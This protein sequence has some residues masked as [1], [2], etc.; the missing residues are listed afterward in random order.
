MA[1]VTSCPQC[2]RKL[3][4]PD[5][6]LGKKVKCPGCGLTFTAMAD[7]PGA[8]PPSPGTIGTEPSRRAMPSPPP[9]KI[10][11]DEEEDDEVDDDDRADEYD[12][13]RPKATGPR[14]AWMSVRLGIIL[15]LCAILGMV[16]CFGIQLIGQ[17]VLVNSMAGR[18]NPNNPVPDMSSLAIFGVCM[19][20]LYLICRA[21]WVA[22]YWFF[23]QVP[24]RSGA[25]PLAGIAFGTGV[26][27]IVLGVITSILMWVMLGS[28]ANMAVDPRNPLGMLNQSVTTTWVIGILMLISLILNLTEYFCCLFF[29]KNVADH[30]RSKGVATSLVYEV[31]FT[32]ITLVMTLMLLVVPF[33]MVGAMANGGGGMRSNGDMFVLL[34]GSCG[35]VTILL[36]LGLVVW[37]I[38]TQFLMLGVVNKPINRR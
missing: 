2:Q 29:Y 7:S 16:I 15:I 21:T 38:V 4:V 30:L 5:E 36:F 19:Q 3:R 14:K 35:C 23:L 6:L 24:E 26:G 33:L 18:F 22:G 12:E 25:K 8:P 27:S 13:P 11:R 1:E 20:L 10:R 17:T 31:V 34:Y 9:R 28:L 37:Y 32:V